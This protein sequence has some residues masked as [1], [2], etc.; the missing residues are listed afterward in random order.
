MK[1]IDYHQLLI[2]YAEGTLS[3]EQREL[4]EEALRSSKSL[5][6]E[7]ESIKLA[8]SSMNAADDPEIPPHYFSTL[9]PNIRI[10]ID[11]GN[12]QKLFIPLWFEK[13]FVPAGTAAVVALIAVFYFTFQP[14][15]VDEGIYQAVKNAQEQDIDVLAS[16]A[17]PEAVSSDNKIIEHLIDILSP[18]NI[19]SYIS[20]Q[21]FADAQLSVSDNRSFDAADVEPMLQGMDD[22]DV[23]QIINTL[24]PINNY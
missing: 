22:T 14:V 19:D 1:H 10:R 16:V 13:L 6:A 11:K 4:I 23:Q 17:T 5:R 15:S 9:L 3:S 18:E 24:Q 21:Y 20:H 12:R 7:Y 2:D 8:F